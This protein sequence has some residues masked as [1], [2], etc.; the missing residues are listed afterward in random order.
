MT[1]VLKLALESNNKT[2]KMLISLLDKWNDKNYDLTD[3]EWNTIKSYKSLL[4][5]FFNDKEEIQKLI[6]SNEET[7]TNL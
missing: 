4:D 3:A 1:N 7:I 6:I 2:Y 5:L